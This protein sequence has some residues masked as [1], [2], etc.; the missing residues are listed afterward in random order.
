[1]KAFKENGSSGVIT[2]FLS[3]ILIPLL[4]FGTLIMEAGR[5]ISA[6]T[7]LAEAQVTASMSLLANYNRYIEER[8]GIL[9]IDSQSTQAEQKD[10]F[11]KL[12]S[13]NNQ[14]LYEIHLKVLLLI[15]H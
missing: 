14:D 1:M 5:Y 2:V 10:M 3:L 12:T 4:A 15:S 7:L 9:A 13:L 6:N 8:F 11:V